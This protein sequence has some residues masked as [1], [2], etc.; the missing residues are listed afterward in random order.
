[1]TMN[2]TLRYGGRTLALTATALG[3]I[4]TAV[5]AAAEEQPTEEQIM[6]DCASG[7][8]K[9]S[10]NSPQ[11]AQAYLG[12]PRQVSELLFNCTD[13]PASQSMSWADTVGSSHSVGGSVTVGGGIE[14]II[15]ASVTAT[16]NYTWQSSRTETSSFTVNVKPGEVGWISRAQVMQRISGT[17]QTHYDDP[18]WDHYYWFVP[19]VITGPAPNGTDGKHSAVVVKSRKMT[20]E[21][22]KLCST[23]DTQDKVFTRS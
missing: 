1:M 22:K 9:C 13:S 18:K 14:G 3:V 19:D 10:F 7:E 4:A 20:A 23:G 2:H 16:Y 12:E 6:A 8:G 17:W 5:P 15:T 21:E 11:L